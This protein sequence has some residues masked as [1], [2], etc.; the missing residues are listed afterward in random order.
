MN[1]RI[2][3]CRYIP[4]PGCRM[5]CMVVC[6]ACIYIV[7]CVAMCHLI[8]CC[9]EYWYRCCRWLDLDTDPIPLPRQVVP[10]HARA[11]VPTLIPPT[12]V[13]PMTRKY[14]VVINPGEQRSLGSH[15]V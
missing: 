6:W 13:L 5:A 7:G 10:L 3:Q 1:M 15:I 11:T 8:A 14:V 2:C 12:K 4:V 9:S